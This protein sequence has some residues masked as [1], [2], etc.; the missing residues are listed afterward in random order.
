MTHGHLGADGKFHP[1]HSRSRCPI[2][3]KAAREKRAGRAGSAWR[4]RRILIL[5]RDG[6]ICADCKGRANS[7]HLPPEW[8]PDHL[9]APDWAFE[10][11]CK[12]CHG[13]RDGGRARQ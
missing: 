4:K 12:Q 1:G 9:T 2:C 8:G 13:R 11:L 3:G 7:V 10:S 5:N 6:W